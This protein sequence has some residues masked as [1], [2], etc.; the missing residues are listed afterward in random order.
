MLNLFK[1]MGLCLVMLSLFSCQAMADKFEYSVPVQAKVGLKLVKSD[2]SAKKYE[3]IGKIESLIGDHKSVEVFFE[4][5]ADFVI[6]PNKK[7]I[8]KVLKK[9][10]AQTFNISAKKV[11]KKVGASGSYV[12]LRIKYIPNYKEMLAKITPENYPKKYPRK[13]LIQAIKVQAE[14]KTPSIKEKTVRFSFGGK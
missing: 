11:D 4:S 2:I 12:R 3:L 1:T 7:E 8:V 14:K 9:G 6:E 10:Q 13:S 5:S